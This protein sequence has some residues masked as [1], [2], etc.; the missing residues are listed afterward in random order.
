MFSF[1][2][3]VGAKK[4]DSNQ[5]FQS[6]QPVSPVDLCHAWVS[7]WERWNVWGRSSFSLNIPVVKRAL[8][9]W[10]IAVPC[11]INNTGGSYCPCAGRSI[12][13]LKQVEGGGGP[14]TRPSRV[15]GPADS[16]LTLG[17]LLLCPCTGLHCKPAWLREGY[18]CLNSDGL[19]SPAGPGLSVRLHPPTN[20]ESRD[21]SQVRDSSIGESVSRRHQTVREWDSYPGCD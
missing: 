13:Q 7:S 19:H 14:F 5:I 9:H 1:S 17:S 21:E 6:Q 2:Q 3:D 12:I 18:M 10:V 15:S 20:P 4:L 16:G 8:L 11:S